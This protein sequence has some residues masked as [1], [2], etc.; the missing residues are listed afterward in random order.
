MEYFSNFREEKNNNKYTF[1]HSSDEC[2]VYAFTIDINTIKILFELS[3]SRYSIED[4]IVI[5]GDDNYKHYSYYKY[6]N[7]YMNIETKSIEESL[8]KINNI[9]FLG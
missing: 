2:I 1:V 7:T 8:T 6:Y 9:K 4:K 5:I 3:K